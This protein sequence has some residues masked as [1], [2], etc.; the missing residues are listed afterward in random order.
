MKMKKTFKEY[1]EINEI[2]KKYELTY[3]INKSDILKI[4][5]EIVF[6]ELEQYEL[7]SLLRAYSDLSTPRSTETDE[8]IWLWTSVKGVVL[9]IKLMADRFGIVKIKWFWD[10]NGKNRT[11]SDG[12]TYKIKNFKDFEIVGKAIDELHNSG[13]EDIIKNKFKKITF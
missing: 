7:S 11:V 4:K 10:P 12:Y 5:D 9:Q 6:N 3:P 1:L 8:T 13:K 2:A